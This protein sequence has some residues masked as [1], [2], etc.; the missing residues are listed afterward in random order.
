LR[1]SRAGDLK[2]VGK[3]NNSRVDLGNTASK[4]ENLF[5]REWVTKK[6][7]KSRWCGRDGREQRS[8]MRKERPV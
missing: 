6:E 1:K 4:G 8:M 5:R 7:K 3:L 2:K